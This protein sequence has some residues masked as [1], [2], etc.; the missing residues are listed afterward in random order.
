MTTDAGPGPGSFEAFFDAH[1]DEVVRA[2]LLI[3]G[4]R[5][6]AEDAAQEAFA[7]ALRRWSRVEVMERPLGWVVVVG[8]NR[9]KRWM[10]RAERLHV[11]VPADRPTPAGGSADHGDHA[12]AIA[13]GSQLRA[14]LDR[15]APRQR[16]TVVLR[17]LCDLPTVEV[18]EALGC[19]PGTVKSAL[20]QALVNLRVELAEGDLVEGDLPG[21]DLMVAGS[22]HDEDGD[23]HGP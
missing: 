19:S 14:A 18:A 16:A 13:V 2:L 6:R 21:G 11:E 8:V 15:L 3:A 10:A 22:T 4:D 7:Q 12:E 9:L 17:Y 5:A 23:R 20:H 1:Y